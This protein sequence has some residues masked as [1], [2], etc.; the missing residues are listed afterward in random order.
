LQPHAVST[1]PSMVS[2]SHS[3]HR[4]CH[5]NMTGL[6]FA[7][8]RFLE[9]YMWN[10]CPYMSASDLE[11]VR[12]AT[13]RVEKES[14]VAP[15]W[16]IIETYCNTAM[17]Q[18]NI[19]SIAFEGRTKETLKEVCLINGPRWILHAQ[20]GTRFQHKPIRLNPIL[21]NQ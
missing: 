2:G 11:T 17:H 13:Q 14:A 20:T 12:Y 10:R 15:Y 4:F 5:Y 3:I 1:P 18:N 9:L 19:W 21:F 6:V 7:T 16:H 8:G